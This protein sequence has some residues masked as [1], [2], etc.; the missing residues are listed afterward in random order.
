MVLEPR[1]LFTAHIIIIAGFALANVPI[2]IMDGLGHHSLLGLSDMVRLEEEAN[3]PSVFSSLALLACALVVRAIR[4]R[5][6][7]GDQDRFAWG[8][9]APFFGFLALD[10]AAMIHEVGNRVG[11]ALGLTGSV[12]VFFYAPVLAWLAARLFPFWLRQERGLRWAL[13]IGSAIY[14]GGA[15]GIELVENHLRSMGHANYDVPMRIGFIAEES[16][17]MLGVAVLLRAFLQRFAIAGGGLLVPLAV[18][19][20]HGYVPGGAA[21]KT[22][23]SSRP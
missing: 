16:A 12:G 18:A 21:Q 1:R 20:A 5:L 14:V 7:A 6:A 4:G 13:F 19:D 8:L 11:T 3:L 9:L 22:L 15:M 23:I 17:E 10:E 2:A